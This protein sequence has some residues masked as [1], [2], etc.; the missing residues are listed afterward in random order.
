MLHRGSPFEALSLFQDILSSGMFL[1]VRVTGR[2]MSPFLTGGEIIMIKKTP[3]SCLRKG[4]LVFFKNLDGHPVIHRIVKKQKRGD[5]ITFQT[6]G[7]ALIG[8]DGPVR[9]EE[10]LGKVCV[11][12]KGEEHYN[13]EAPHWRCANYLRAI[14]N[15][16]ESRLY[17]R[18]SVFK[19]LLT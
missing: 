3:A 8:F 7:D 14:I 10:I 19:K 1:R 18:L 13:L 4:D 5:D 11:V 17:S 2:S 16:Y 12:E 15:L 9:E 6:R